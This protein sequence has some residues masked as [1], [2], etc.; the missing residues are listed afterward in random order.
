MVRVFAYFP[1]KERGNF[2][3]K[4]TSLDTFFLS[5]IITIQV[6]KFELELYTNFRKNFLADFTHIVKC[7]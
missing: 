6:K 7:Y 5:Y 4:Y 1:N 2:E 3:N